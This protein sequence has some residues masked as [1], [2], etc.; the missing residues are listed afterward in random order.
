MLINVRLPLA[1]LCLLL[2]LINVL[3]LGVCYLQICE[4]V[5]YCAY[6]LMGTMT[7][8][9]MRYYL[10]CKNPIYCWIVCEW[11]SI[12]HICVVHLLLLFFLFCAV[13][14]ATLHHNTK[15]H[16]FFNLMI[17]FTL[18]IDC[19]PVLSHIHTTHNHHLHD[20][21]IYEMTAFLC[22]YLL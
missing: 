5:S 3:W 7:D 15:T 17:F 10:W 9:D 1:F 20:Y 14:I 2:F 18:H 12:T 13:V 21:P 16:F 19:I 8:I 4:Y 11:S 22:I 6:Q